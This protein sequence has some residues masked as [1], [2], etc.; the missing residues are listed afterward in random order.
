MK[1][2]G[3]KELAQDWM[4]QA[5]EAE[6]TRVGLSLGIFHP[7]EMGRAVLQTAINEAYFERYG[8][9]FEE[10][11]LTLIIRKTIFEEQRV[12]T[13]PPERLDAPLRPLMGVSFVTLTPASPGWLLVTFSLGM[14]FAEATRSSGL[15]FLLYEDSEEGELILELP[16]LKK[17]DTFHINLPDFSGLRSHVGV[18]YDGSLN[19]TVLRSPAIRTLGRAKA[20]H[21][22]TLSAQAAKLHKLSGASLLGA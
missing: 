5:S 4:Q 6:L 16:L 12:F 21:G 8:R 10:Q 13:L 1:A 2:F 7:E 15:L 17:R 9:L 14:L 22:A 20:L 19:R 11:D 18:I 3:K